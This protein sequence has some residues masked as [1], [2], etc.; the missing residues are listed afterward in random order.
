MLLP[1]STIS[2]VRKLFFTG[3]QHCKVEWHSLGSLG[4]GLNG[5]VHT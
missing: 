4:T 2:V 5:I 3:Q 1:F